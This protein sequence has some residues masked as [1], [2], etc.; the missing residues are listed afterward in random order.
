[1]ERETKLT[2]AVES[3]GSRVHCSTTDSGS[4]YSSQYSALPSGPATSCQSCIVGKIAFMAPRR[5][6]CDGPVVGALFLFGEDLH[7][8]DPS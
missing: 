8:S 4:A 3:F 6:N 2:E 5:D 1:M 7:G